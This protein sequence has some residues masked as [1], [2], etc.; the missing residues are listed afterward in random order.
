MTLSLDLWTLI[1]QLIPLFL[2]TLMFVHLYLG[3]YWL[4]S[5]QLT[6][7]QQYGFHQCGWQY[8][9]FMVML[10]FPSLCVLLRVI[11]STKSNENILQITFIRFSMHAIDAFHKPSVNVVKRAL[12]KETVCH[13]ERQNHARTSSP[14]QYV[15]IVHTNG[16]SND[17][18]RNNQ[19]QE[20]TY[21]KTYESVHRREHQELVNDRQRTP[22]PPVRRK[23]KEQV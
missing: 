13:P 4:K 5:R 23:S 11:P 2:E 8:E 12:I 20:S 6:L 21:S 1:V 3:N 10:N 14:S 18:P 16:N 7:H 22:S 19:V 17:H 15:E 9:H